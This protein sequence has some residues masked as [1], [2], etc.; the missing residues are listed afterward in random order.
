MLETLADI[1]AIGLLIEAIILTF[2]VGAILFVISRFG[3]GFVLT[4]ARQ[5]FGIGR[6]VVGR[7]EQVTANVGNKAVAPNVWLYGRAAWL[8]AFFASL[9]SGWR[10]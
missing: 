1:S 4:K 5:G 7:T 9:S 2:V 3:M 10:R 6:S 8:R